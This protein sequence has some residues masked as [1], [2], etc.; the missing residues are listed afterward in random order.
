MQDAQNRIWQI[1]STQEVTIIFNTV[2]SDKNVK[3]NLPN[4]IMDSKLNRIIYP[5]LQG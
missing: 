1:V 4:L 5:M 3:I 2:K